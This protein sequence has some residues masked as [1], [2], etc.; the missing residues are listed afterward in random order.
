MVTLWSRDN[1]QLTILLYLSRLSAYVPS[2]SY[3]IYL[4][5][6]LQRAFLL[7]RTSSATYMKDV[8]FENFSQLPLP[9]NL[10]RAFTRAFAA[11]IHTS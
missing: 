9:Y 6:Q 11:R 10:N 1:T 3:L 5:I 4:Q 7:K 2:L 8:N